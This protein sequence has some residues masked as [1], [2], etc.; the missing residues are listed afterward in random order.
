MAWKALKSTATAIDIDQRRHLTLWEKENKKL[1][2]DINLGKAARPVSAYSYSGQSLRPRSAATTSASFAQEA[3][4][5]D[6]T[7]VQYIEEEADT[8]EPAHE[9]AISTKIG[10][11]GSVWRDMSKELEG[12]RSAMDVKT[13]VWS[14]SWNPYASETLRETPVAEEERRRPDTAGSMRRVHLDGKGLRGKV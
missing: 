9:E 5:W 10:E 12:P 11:T 3:S 2:T 13:G 1:A 6:P 14:K 4:V 7:E 8:E